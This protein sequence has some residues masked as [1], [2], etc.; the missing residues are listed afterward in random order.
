MTPWPTP[1]EPGGRTR[2]ASSG[3]TRRP[4]K[5]QSVT[6]SDHSFCPAE[7]PS[8]PDHQCSHRAGYATSARVPRGFCHGVPRHL[9]P[10]ALTRLG[11]IRSIS[12]PR[13]RGERNHVA[14][15][16]SREAM[17]RRA[18][19][20]AKSRRGRSAPCWFG[21]TAGNSRRDR[22]APA[23]TAPRVRLGS[24]PVFGR[25][26]SFRS[27]SGWKRPAAMNQWL[28]IAAEQTTI[29]G[30]FLEHLANGGLAA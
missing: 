27:R 16:H 3:R 21:V 12:H 30:N 24:V 19:G 9:G 8:R 25:A 15:Q 13:N 28:R 22:P 18:L 14:K 26:V 10:P 17:A 11:G 5:G 4:E 1:G 2:S 23:F 6:I 29:T 20:A 7:W